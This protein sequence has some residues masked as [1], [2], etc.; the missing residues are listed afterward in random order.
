MT[1][2]KVVELGPP[3]PGETRVK[4]TKRMPSGEA[5]PLL[6][7]NYNLDEVPTEWGTF[8]NRDKLTYRELLLEYI[9]QH[10]DSAGQPA[11]FMILV[12]GL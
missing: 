8:R 3:A 6:E 12:E 5:L 11:Q 9:G 4:V 10:R 2:T 7:G 1:D